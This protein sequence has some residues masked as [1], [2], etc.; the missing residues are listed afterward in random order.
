M[1]S[2][3]TITYNRYQC[4]R[5][6]AEVEMSV[7]QESFLVKHEAHS[8]LIYTV[9]HGMVPPAEKPRKGC[10]CDIKA[11]SFVEPSVCK[12]LRFCSEPDPRAVAGG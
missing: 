11:V 8:G 5:T 1:K 9:I 12:N 2:E 10:M 7:T 4:F 6:S 3:N